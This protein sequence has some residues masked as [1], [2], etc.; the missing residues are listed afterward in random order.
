MDSV[1]RTVWG[2]ARIWSAT[3]DANQICVEFATDWFTGGAG[4]TYIN[5]RYAKHIDATVLSSGA[6]EH[7]AKQVSFL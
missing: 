1:T 7:S 6:L 5:K 4:F 2:C 3:Q